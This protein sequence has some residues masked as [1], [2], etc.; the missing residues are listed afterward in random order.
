MSSATS[1]VSIWLA[2]R[3]VF[4]SAPALSSE[5]V[6]TY[7]DTLAVY[8]FGSTSHAKAAVATANATGSAT[9]SFR[10]LRSSFISSSSV[11]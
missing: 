9:T 6:S 7:M 11:M 10:C 1:L 8:V 5:R 2:E 4:V 3:S